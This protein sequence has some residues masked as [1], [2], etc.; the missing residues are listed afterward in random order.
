MLR[1]ASSCSEETPSRA[2]PVENFLRRLTSPFDAAVN[3][4]GVNTGTSMSAFHGGQEWQALPHFIEDLSVTTNG[5]G[6]PSSAMAAACE[7]VST[8][9]HYPPV[10]FEPHLSELSQ[11][12]WGAEPAT[13]RLLLGNGASELIDLLT[14]DAALESDEAPGGWRC[15]LSGI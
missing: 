3:G 8:V 10:S 7:A 11:F 5:L 1:M 13:D 4:P 2:H 15:G 9:S 12:L 6:P 14:R